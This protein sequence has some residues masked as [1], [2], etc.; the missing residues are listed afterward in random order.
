MQDC[1]EVFSSFIKN[2]TLSF[3]FIF[4]DIFK[5]LLANKENICY[6]T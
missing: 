3:P 5:I 2:E 6:Y 4:P 1:Q